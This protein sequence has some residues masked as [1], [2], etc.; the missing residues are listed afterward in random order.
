MLVKMQVCRDDLIMREDWQK[1]MRDKVRRE[2]EHRLQL[3]R[4]TKHHGEQYT[5]WSPDR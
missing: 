3:D 1:I 5:W 2:R 4:L